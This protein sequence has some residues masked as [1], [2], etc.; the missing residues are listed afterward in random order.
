MN[1]MS[2][3][4]HVLQDETIDRLCHESNNREEFNYSNFVKPSFGLF[5]TQII[6]N[7]KTSN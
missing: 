7:V 3:I 1:E 5:I 4:D 2:N 6:S